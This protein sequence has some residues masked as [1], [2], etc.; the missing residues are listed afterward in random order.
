MPVT[1]F[2]CYGYLGTTVCHKKCLLNLLHA[3]PAGNHKTG[4]TNNLTG[5]L[6]AVMKQPLF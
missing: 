2:Q 3:K 6:G 4:R 1:T 5:F